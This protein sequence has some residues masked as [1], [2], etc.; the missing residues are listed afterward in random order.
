MWSNYGLYSVS[1]S[2]MKLWIKDIIG[3]PLTF[4]RKQNYK[5]NKF[6]VWPLFSELKAWHQY[7]L[8][9]CLLVWSADNFCKQFG[10]KSWSKLFDTLMVFLKEFFEK[11]DFEKK[12]A[13]DKGHEK[14]PSI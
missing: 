10:P 9:L 5:M 8:T 13:D 2:S 12:K 4:L 1:L 14:L 7:S 3:I 11:V 6:V